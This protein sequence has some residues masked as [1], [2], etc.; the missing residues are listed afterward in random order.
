MLAKWHRVREKGW[1]N[2]R[3]LLPI[4]LCAAL[5]ACGLPNKH[6]KPPA[7]AAT[8]QPRLVGSVALVNTD[9]GFV[10]VDVGSLYIPAPGSSLICMADGRK[11]AD[12]KSTPEKK[13]PFIS[14]DIVKGTP[15]QGDQ[16]FEP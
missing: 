16:V 12:I 8:T 1:M 6:A 15:G 5:A 10:L 14:A 7:T 11:T 3:I 4:A 13:I 9:L 2:P